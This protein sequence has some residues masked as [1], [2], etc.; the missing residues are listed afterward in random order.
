MAKDEKVFFAHYPQFRATVDGGREHDLALYGDLTA[1]LNTD[2]IIGFLNDTNM[3]GFSFLANA[4]NPLEEFQ[5][6]W[7]RPERE[8][9]SPT[10]ESLR[11]RLW[12]KANEY[13]NFINLE[14]YPA[15]L[16]G[17][18][19]VPED[20]ENTQPDRFRRIVNTLHQLAGE[21]VDLHRELVRT[22]RKE[23][24]AS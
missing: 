12:V 10:L 13:M 11:S 18:Q 23:L 16:P 3:A 9:I 6:S 2:G 24:I 5:H 22:G 7:N 15:H 21:I 17:R 8:F 19:T 4:L 20:W 14:T 1:L